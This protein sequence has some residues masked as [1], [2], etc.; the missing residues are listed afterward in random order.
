MYAAPFGRC[1]HE[2][3]EWRGRAIS[4]SVSPKTSRA[5]LISGGI[6]LA[7]A[8]FFTLTKDNTTKKPSSTQARPVTVTVRGGKPVGGVRTMTVRSGQT[9]SITVD[10][11]V[12]DEVHVHGYDKHAEVAAGT[13][14]TISF[15]ATIAGRFTIELERRSE[16]ILTLVVE[17]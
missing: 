16:Q 11:D 15:P 9:V 4:P 13:P 12:A 6:L 8:M 17:P 1:R 14:V 2:P 10:S 5:F 7:I 3:P